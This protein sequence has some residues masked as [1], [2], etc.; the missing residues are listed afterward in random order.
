M[1]NLKWEGVVQTIEIGSFWIEYQNKF[2]MW[3]TFQPG[4]LNSTPKIDKIDLIYKITGT[5]KTSLFVFS[6]AYSEYLTSFLIRS[7]S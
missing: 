1:L 7:H 4:N 6:I 2:L 5:T 3:P